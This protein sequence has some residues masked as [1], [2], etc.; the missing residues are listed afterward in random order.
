MKSIIKTLLLAAAFLTIAQPIA[1]AIDASFLSGEAYASNLHPPRFIRG[2]LVC[3]LNVGRFLRQIGKRGTGSASAS[4]FMA[5]K[6]V[7]YPSS[8]DVVVNRRPG[9]WHVQIYDGAAMCWNPSSRH[10]RWVYQ[11]CD[12]TWRGRRKIYLRSF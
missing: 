8:G 12:A 1:H 11:S 3:A 5:F 9:G 10:Q 4:S 7:A 2:K 6:R